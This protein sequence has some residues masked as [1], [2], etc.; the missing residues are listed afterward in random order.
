MSRFIIGSRAEAIAA[1]RAQVA[2]LVVAEARLLDCISEA[3]DLRA[4]F[5]REAHALRGGLFKGELAHLQRVLTSNLVALNAGSEDDMAAQHA[6]LG[7]RRAVL[8]KRRRVLAEDLFLDALFIAAQFPGGQISEAD[9]CCYAYDVRACAGLCRATWVEE[10]F[11]SGL[12]RVS[13]GWR[14]RTRLMYAAA[15]GDAARVAWLLA[16]GAPREAQDANGR[17]A[18]HWASTDGRTDAMRALL[19]AGANINAAENGGRTPLWLAAHEGQA[20]AVHALLEE[21]ANVDAAAGGTTPLYTAAFAGHIDVLRALLA[22]GAAVDSQTGAGSSPLH[23]AARAIDGNE[24]VHVLCNAGAD[25]DSRDV[26]GETPLIRAVKRGRLDA[27]RALMS[28]DANFEAADDAGWRPLHYAVA[29][30]RLSIAALLLMTGANRA[31]ATN[32]GEMPS[33]LIGSVAMQ[34]LFDEADGGDGDDEDEE[35]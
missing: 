8:G 25:V 26:R 19:A 20:D 24:G 12:A 30:E 27:V 5:G 13:S 28:W 35:D 18:L 32:A 31:A 2:A 10:A 7:K 15:Q 6:A 14:K 23:A 3:T 9:K 17:T 21:G 16:R 34:Q 4:A 1:L 33:D 22:G 29:C 11:W